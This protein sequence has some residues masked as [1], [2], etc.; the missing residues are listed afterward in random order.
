M[1]ILES[2]MD[3]PV[4]HH[5]DIVACIGQGAPFT[6]CGSGV[7]GKEGVRHFYLINNH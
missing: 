7:D 2:S 3:F 6:V 4:A 5:H 1:N